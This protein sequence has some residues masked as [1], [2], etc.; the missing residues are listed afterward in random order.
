MSD[1]FTP[2]SARQERRIELDPTIAEII[3]GNTRAGVMLV[4]FAALCLGLAGALVLK[5][6]TEIARAE[7]MERPA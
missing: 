4:L 2:F 1:H 7:Q 3:L 5:R 6:A